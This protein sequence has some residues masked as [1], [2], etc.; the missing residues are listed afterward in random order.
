MDQLT[1]TK[2]KFN[3]KFFL[4]FCCFN[5]SR[6]N[7]RNQQNL[8]EPRSPI[9][10]ATN[11]NDVKSPVTANARTQRRQSLTGIHASGS[12]QSRRSS[13]GGKPID[14]SK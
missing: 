14:S 3:L 13:L 8:M 6:P 9:K 10:A 1:S 12:D 11:I 2:S 7:C 5:I 4:M